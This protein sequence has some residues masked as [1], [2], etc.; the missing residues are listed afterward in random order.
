MTVKR[1]KC[2]RCQAVS[3]LPELLRAP[4]PFDP[5]DELIGCPACKR[6]EGFTALCETPDCEKPATCGGTFE[7]GVY[8]HTCGHHADWLRKSH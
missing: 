5:D 2:D 3:L 4:S 6:C 1:W 7:D 8:R